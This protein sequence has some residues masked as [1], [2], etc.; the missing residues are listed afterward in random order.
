MVP[1]EESIFKSMI[2]KRKLFLTYRQNDAPINGP[3]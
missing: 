3:R 1:E 2:L